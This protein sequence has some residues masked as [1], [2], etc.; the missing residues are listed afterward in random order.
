MYCYI[1]EKETLGMHMAR[2]REKG[3]TYVFESS[4]KKRYSDRGVRRM[5][6]LEGGR[7]GAQPVAAPTLALPARASTRP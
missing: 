6:M 5:L 4:W 1:E 3:A 7:L 2:M